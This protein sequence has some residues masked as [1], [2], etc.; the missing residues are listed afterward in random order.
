MWLAGWTSLLSPPPPQL[1]SQSP[2]AT[3][4]TWRDLH[5]WA[6]LAP[7]WPGAGIVPKGSSTNGFSAL[8]LIGREQVA[9]IHFFFFCFKRQP[10][11]SLP[12]PPP[13]FQFCFIAVWERCGAGKCS[14]PLYSFSPFALW[15]DTLDYFSFHRCCLFFLF[16]FVGNWDL[17]L[18]PLSLWILT[19]ESCAFEVSDKMISSYLTYFEPTNM[20]LWVLYHAFNQD[21]IG[22]F[23]CKIKSRS[24]YN[25]QRTGGNENLCHHNRVPFGYMFCMGTHDM[26]RVCSQENVI[27]RLPIV[28]WIKQF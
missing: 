3:E 25:S 28:K 8:W 17:T 5:S 11:R 20:L 23:S 22:L 6:T 24:S 27:M 13:P 1:P 18:S 26:F 7:D 9:S 2:A 4:L 12:P 16:I 14:T 15:R 19:A 10:L 21:I